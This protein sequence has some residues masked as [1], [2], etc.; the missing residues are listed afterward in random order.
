MIYM[1]K[2]T[3]AILGTIF[4]ALIACSIQSTSADHLEPGQGLFSS[5]EEVELVT[6]D[7]TK[8]QVHLQ[9]V[10]RTGDGQLITVDEEPAAAYV[11]H[12]ISDYVFDTLMGE[13]EIVT[14][15]NI[16]YEKVQY[17][18]TPTFKQ[19]WIGLY[20]INPEPV[21]N[22]IMEVDDLK[23][24]KMKHKHYSIWKIHGCWD[25]SN[26]GHPGVQC[27]PI[28]QV[29][30]PTMVLEADDTVTNQWTILR[31]LS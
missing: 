24:A 27:L 2:F 6:T 1:K 16:K 25:L 30:V 9:T 21:V 22:L 3:I 23:Q 15:D 29:L 5:E 14:I 10:I 7:G 12:E 31:E 18:F 28:F 13:K 19:R 8:Y 26:I 11:P 17:T 4:V 20:Q